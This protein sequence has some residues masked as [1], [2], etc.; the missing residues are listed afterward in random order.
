[1]NGMIPSSGCGVRPW[2]VRRPESALDEITSR[3]SCVGFCRVRQGK[4]SGGGET[5]GSYGGGNGHVNERP[6]KGGV[7]G[8][9]LKIER[10]W[11]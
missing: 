1:M 6:L 10:G 4:T 3:H 9:F 5:V 2:P 11:R 7:E 8:A